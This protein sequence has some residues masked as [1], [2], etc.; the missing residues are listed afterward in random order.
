MAKTILLKPIKRLG[1]H[2]RMIL[3]LL[4]AFVLFFAVNIIV[5]QQGKQID[6]TTL[7]SIEL[8]PATLDYLN[9]E[10]IQQRDRPIKIIAAINP[11]EFSRLNVDSH[12]NIP[13]H[14]QAKL[15]E[16]GSNS[17]KKID[18]EFVNPII[19]HGRTHQLAQLYQHHFT[20]S[21]FIIDARPEEKPSPQLLE[22]LKKAN[23]HLKEE[24]ILRLH[25]RDLLAKHVRFV[26]AKRLFHLEK[27]I[28]Y[29][30]FYISFWKDEAEL[31]THMMSAVEG[32]PRII[33]FLFDKC[34]LEPKKGKGK[35]PWE[36]MRAYL[37]SQNIDLRPLRMSTILNHSDPSQ[38]K[39]PED[40]NGVALIAPTM[41]FSDKE[42]E[43]LR[44]YWQVREKSSLLITLDPE[45]HLPR[46]NRFLF[47]SGVRPRKDRII[48]KENNQILVNPEVFFLQGPKVNGELVTKSTTFDGPSQS[49]EVIK[50]DKN[51]MVE[52]FGI[53]Q[54]A[55]EWWGE[56][57][58]GRAEVSFD[59]RSDH[60]SPLFLGA[61]VT[62]GA[63]NDEKKAN[64]ASKMVILG[65]SEFMSDENIRN[66][67]L[68]FL[69]QAGNWLVGRESLKADIRQFSNIRRKVFIAG[70]HKDL[71]NKIFL[72]FLPLFSLLIVGFVWNLRRS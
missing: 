46:L 32:K 51:N 71:L 44:E 42:L 17:N 65:N 70:P 60:G 72:F 15:Q 50:N 19:D 5:S 1:L 68:T 47:E 12:E 66:E 64:L 56:S 31:T 24:E 2:A 49:I 25:A 62:R 14:I 69:I 27:D 11:R 6:L 23:S 39:I 26:P 36:N 35:A 43:V 9:S 40:A 59:E 20:E 29:D 13:A 67:Q 4:A 45:S 28:V 57:R 54:V 41:D 63:L 33:Y 58:F 53:I 21:V 30:K 3:T 52:P 37:R 61:A 22:R 48:R 18:V 7:S 34:Q 55:P 10:N 38:R 8:S 16:Y